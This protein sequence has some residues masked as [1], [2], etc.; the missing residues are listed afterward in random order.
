MAHHDVC[1]ARFLDFL[2]ADLGLALSS[3]FSGH[4]FAHLHLHLAT[5][6]STEKLRAR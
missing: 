1:A 5:V 6:F 4:L 3:I 2:R